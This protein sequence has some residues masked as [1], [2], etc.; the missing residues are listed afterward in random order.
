MQGGGECR[1]GRFVAVVDLFGPKVSVH[2]LLVLRSSAELGELS[3]WRCHDDITTY[4]SHVCDF[5]CYFA[6]VY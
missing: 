2:S 1:L 6:V 4:Q 5:G 3:H